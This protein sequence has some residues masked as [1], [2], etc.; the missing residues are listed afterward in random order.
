M[1]YVRCH[2]GIVQAGYPTRRHERHHETCIGRCRF[3]LRFGTC[4]Y[5]PWRWPPTRRYYRFPFRQDNAFVW[6]ATC[7]NTFV[8]S[9]LFALATN[10]G[11]ACIA[12]DARKRL[13]Y[14]NQTQ[15]YFFVSAIVGTSGLMGPDASSRFHEIGRNISQDRNDPNQTSVLFQ[16]FSMTIIKV[17]A[18]SI[19]TSARSVSPFVCPFSF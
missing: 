16:R 3:P 9:N 5:R 18:F 8:P 6:D 4:E 7:T 11:S 19:M 15:H 14:A 12:A 13:G 2:V 17:D 1:A 10:P